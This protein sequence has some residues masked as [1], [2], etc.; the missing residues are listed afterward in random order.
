MRAVCLPVRS[1]ITEATLPADAGPD[2]DPDGFPAAGSSGSPSSADCSTVP[3]NVRT[4]WLAAS[5]RTS[6]GVLAGNGLLAPAGR[7]PI[8]APQ[9]HPAPCAVSLHLYVLERSAGIQPV[10]AHGSRL[11]PCRWVR[12]LGNFPVL[13]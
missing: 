13:R 8:R 3:E 10:G 1:S 2:A 5:S 6:A 7:D 9:P 12:A 4:W 11:R